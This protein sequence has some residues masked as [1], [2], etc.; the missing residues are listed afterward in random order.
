MVDKEKNAALELL[1][2]HGWQS[3]GGGF[4]AR[5][6]G[7]LT[8]VC[9][10]VDAVK[11]Q[12]YEDWLAALDAPAVCVWTYDEDT[13]KWDA[14]C[15]TGNSFVVNSGNPTDSGMRFCTFCGRPIEEQWPNP[16]A[17]DEEEAGDA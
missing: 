12:L 1:A 9:L 8:D 11:N 4:W 5:Q 17:Q 14:A 15:G 7:E 13:D 6:R 3:K 10:T 2:A 16:R